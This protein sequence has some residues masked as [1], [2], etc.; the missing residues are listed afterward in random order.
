ML[1]QNTFKQ[2]IHTLIRNINKSLKLLLS[3]KK[4]KTADYADA[5]FITEKSV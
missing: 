1:L 5:I 2:Q 4:L 3:Q